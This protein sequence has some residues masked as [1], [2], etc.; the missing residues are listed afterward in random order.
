MPR[1]RV[2]ATLGPASRDESTVRALVEPGV[3]VFRLSATV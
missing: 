2:V 3:D 1:T